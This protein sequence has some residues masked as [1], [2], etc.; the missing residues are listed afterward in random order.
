MIQKD[1]IENHLNMSDEKGPGDEQH[2]YLLL[3]KTEILHHAE[4]PEIEQ[5]DDH[6]RSSDDDEEE[7]SSETNKLIGTLARSIQTDKVDN[8]E[9][10]NYNQETFARADEPDWPTGS[11]QSSSLI[12]SLGAA[13]RGA[14]DSPLLKPSAQKSKV[15]PN[16]ESMGDQTFAK[17]L[18]ELEREG[19]RDSLQTMDMDPSTLDKTLSQIDREQANTV[20]FQDNNDD[21]DD[22]VKDLGVSSRSKAGDQLY[23]DAIDDELILGTHPKPQPKPTSCFLCCPKKS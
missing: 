9:R 2:K 10:T 16:W 4:Q 12:S 1:T 21:E 11:Q 23:D 13:T 6:E 7:S 18:S 8:L 14:Q 15:K 5:Q 19:R 22:I 20:R 17:T 3:L